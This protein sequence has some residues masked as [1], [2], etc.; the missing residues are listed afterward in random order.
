MRYT[1]VS[2][3]LNKCFAIRYEGG[4]RKLICLIFFLVLVPSGV[5]AQLC[6]IFPLKIICS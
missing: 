3:V 4:E 6:N 5:H 1:A 2:G